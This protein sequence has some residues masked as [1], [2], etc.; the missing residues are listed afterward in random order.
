MP[1]KA[2]KTHLDSLRSELAQ[3]DSLDAETR[4]MLA[5]LAASIEKTLSSTATNHDSL[6]ERI[7]STT[8]EFEA[9]HPNFSRIL[10]EVSDT[11]AKLGV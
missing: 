11:L 8:L 7:E 10:S 9:R 3:A 5:E 1:Q 6:R 4:Q 2:L